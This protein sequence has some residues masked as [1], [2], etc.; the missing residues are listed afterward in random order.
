MG[1]FNP[2]ERGRGVPKPR[3]RHVLPPGDCPGAVTFELGNGFQ[4][5][6][7]ED[8]G[9]FPHI[10]LQKAKGV[11][12]VGPA[13]TPLVKCGQGSELEG[14]V[15]SVPWPVGPCIGDGGNFSCVDGVD[16]TPFGCD[17][18][19]PVHGFHGFDASLQVFLT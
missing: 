11:I 7:T 18:E 13:V 5:N 8:E 2:H 12:P 9:I 14:N 3:S 1:W 10:D 17:K 19:D 4:R 6:K 16:E 15:L